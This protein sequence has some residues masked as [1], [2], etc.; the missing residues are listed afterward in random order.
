MFKTDARGIEFAA[1]RSRA[2]MDASVK[3]IDRNT[4]VVKDGATATSAIV[5]SNDVADLE[6]AVDASTIDVTVVAKNVACLETILIAF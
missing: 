4:A 2:K 1:N 5:G 3:M 6:F